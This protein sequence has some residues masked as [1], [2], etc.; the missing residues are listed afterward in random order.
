MSAIGYVTKQ[1][2]G[3]RGKFDLLVYRGPLEFVPNKNRTG[4]QPHFRLFSRTTEVGAA[5][6]AQN[7]EGEDYVSI[8][9]H[10]PS[11]G[12]N[13]IYAN[14]GVAGDQN[15]PDTFAIIWNPKD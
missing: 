15:D 14:L 11:F 8:D 12:P 4:N 10:H 9:F 7:Q 1:G 2:E 5:W 13:R 3:Y 6:I